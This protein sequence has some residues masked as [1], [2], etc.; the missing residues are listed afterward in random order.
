MLVLRE[1]T[2]LQR[3]RPQTGDRSDCYPLGVKVV[4]LAGGLG[5]RMREET[6]F[7]P[8]P[9]VEI[10]QIPIIVHLM[11]VFALQGHQEFIVCAGYK[12]QLIQNFLQ[13]KTWSVWRERRIPSWG[14]EEWTITVVDTGIETP[15]GGRINHVRD[16]IGDHTFFCTYGDGLAPVNLRNLL[17]KHQSGGVSATVTLAHP[18]SRFGVAE[19]G[20][21][22]K[23]TGFREKPVLEDL[24]SMGFFVFEKEV[25]DFLR[26]DSV[27]E[28][29]PLSRLAFEHELTGCVHDG[30]W[31]PLD[32]YRELLV[33][34]K[35][36]DSGTAPWFEFPRDEQI[37][38]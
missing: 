5:T 14:G 19:M 1:V 20:S 21:D 29:E 15:T 30:F 7:T 37:A 26:P 23:I 6:E 4:L 31:Q 22:G 16:L 13:V 12:A 18:T 32:T 2:T 3:T 9:M 25:F 10:G 35:L 36:W 11:H 27:L 34:Q 38:F 24:V 8:K 17:D 28:E 33:M